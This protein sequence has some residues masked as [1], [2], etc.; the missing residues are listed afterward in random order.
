MAG[1][2]R[3][4]TFK[5]RGGG[6]TSGFV[7]PPFGKSKCS[8]FTICSY[9]V[10]KK[11]I[12]IIFLARVARQLLLINVFQTSNARYAKCLHRPIVIINQQYTK[13]EIHFINISQG[14]K[15]TH[16]F[17]VF[18]YAKALGLLQLRKRPLLIEFTIW[19]IFT[20]IQSCS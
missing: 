1:Y 19:T 4:P 3:A 11:Q 17:F 14:T 13:G 5:K 6:G 12:C 15:G 2:A 8:N 9:F 18:A 10:I 16:F 20:L 7:A